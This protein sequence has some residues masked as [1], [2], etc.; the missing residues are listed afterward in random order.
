MSQ[1]GADDALPQDD[2]LGP[3]ALRGQL[4]KGYVGKIAGIPFGMGAAHNSDDSHA[5]PPAEVSATVFNF[6]ITPLP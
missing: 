1:A 3:N 4:L 5:I 2:F 6:Q